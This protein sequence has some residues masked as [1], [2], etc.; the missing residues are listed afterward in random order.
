LENCS[1]A[2]SDLGL[3]KILN[4]GLHDVTFFRSKLV[5]IDW[6]KANK[7]MS[8]GFKSC[9][10]SNVSFFGI[11]LS[12]TNFIDCQLR[13][14]DFAEA[15]LSRCVCRGSDFKEARFSNTDLS[16]ADF[17]NAQG[18]LICPNSNTLKKTRFSLPEAVSLL[19]GLD[20]IIE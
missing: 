2:D 6:T 1:F 17:T 13:N 15:N 8:V 3:V 18:Y 4:S 10:L 20:I 9:N 16:Y 14:V 7:H 5:G 19:S 11:N 12:K